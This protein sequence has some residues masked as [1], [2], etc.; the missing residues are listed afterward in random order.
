[1][2]DSETASAAPGTFVTRG[3]FYAFDR[4][5]AMTH[6]R[7]LALPAEVSAALLGELDALTHTGPVYVELAP[8]D[9]A[10]FAVHPFDFVSV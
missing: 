7:S 8:G 9:D 3:E 10:L 2:S 5:H 6:V 1:M 4:F